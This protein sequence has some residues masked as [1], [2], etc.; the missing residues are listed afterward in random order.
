VI[1]DL[2]KAKLIE[3]AEEKLA[4]AKLL[5]E[6]GRHAS[7]HYL[8]G[9]AIELLLKAAISSRFQADTIPDPGWLNHIFQHNLE[10]LT[11]SAVLDER[12]DLQSDA[13]SNFKARWSIVLERNEPL[14][15][16]RSGRRRGADRRD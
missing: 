5:L 13:D 2:S 7:A 6:N 15:R 10:Q 9:Y 12:L 4:D 14:L 8:A 16:P 3:L 11:K 1:P